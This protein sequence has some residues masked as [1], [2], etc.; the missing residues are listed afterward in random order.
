MLPKLPYLDPPASVVSSRILDVVEGR[1]FVSRVA[2]VEKDG[3]PI[4]RKQTT[5]ELAER[6]HALLSLLD[7]DHFPKPISSWRD[8]VASVC[9]MERVDGYPLSDLERFVAETSPEGARAFLL[10][11]VEILAELAARGI[12]H[13]D[14]R[15]DNI[16]VRDGRPVLIDFGW[17]VSPQHPYI[18][19]GGLG[20]AGRAPEGFCDAYAMG[21]AL[22]PAF[23]HHPELLHVLAAM[24]RPSAAGRV[25]DPAAL[26]ELVDAGSPAPA[27]VAAAVCRIA[28]QAIASGALEPAQAALE[29]ALELAPDD[30]ALLAAAGTVRLALGDA[31]AAEALLER[32]L[33]IDPENLTARTGLAHAAVDQ[34]RV[35][36]A[37]ERYAA[38]PGEA[39]AATIVIPV[40]N[41]VDLTRQCLATLA[42]ST[43]SH[44]YEVVVVDNGSTDETAA[45]LRRAR[46]A[47][48]LRAVFNGENLGFGK[49]CN[50]GASLARGSSIVLLNNDTIPGEGWLEALL[51]VAVD[52]TVGIVGSRLLYPDGRLQHAGIALNAQGLPYHIHRHEPAQF[53]PALVQRDFPA[54]TG[55]SM[56]L[57][58]EVYEQLGGFDEMFQM[59]VEDVDLC[60]RA[61]EAGLRV[62]YCPKSLLVHLESASV[63]DLARR[64]EQVRTGWGLLRSRWDGKFATPPWGGQEPERP[65]VTLDGVRSFA[66]LAF[67]DE[68]V[69]HPEILRTYTDTFGDRDDAS[70]VIY[71]PGRQPA[72]IAGALGQ[73]MRQAGS[74]RRAAPT[75]SSSPPTAAARVRP[76]SPVRSTRPTRGATATVPSRASTTSTT[77]ASP[78]CGCSR[79]G[80]GGAWRRELRSSAARL[81]GLA[82]RPVR[83]RGRGSRIPDRAR[84]DGPP[85]RG[86]RH[87]LHERPGAAPVGSPAG[88]RRRD[89][90]HAGGRVRPRPPPHPGPEPAAA[91]RGPRRRPDDVRDYS[92]PRAWLPRLYECDEVWVPCEFNLE[93]F[94]RGGFP[95]DRLRVLPET[96]DFDLFDPERTEP[97]AAQGARGFTFLTNFDFTDR[98]GWDVLLDAW[99]DA[100]DADDDVCLVLKCLGLHVPES[101]IRGRIDAY[102]GGRPA[103]PILLD[104]PTCSAADTRLYAAP[105]VRARE[106]RRGLGPPVITMAMGLRRSAAAGAVPRCSCTTELVACRRRRRRRARHGARARGLLLQRPAAGSIPTRARS[107]P[108]SRGVPAPRRGGREG[109]RARTD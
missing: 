54:V 8:G 7:S 57:R 18:T 73:A 21:V 19:P 82:V 90:A 10:E 5:F 64:D 60:L 25:T 43:P 68:L 93:T 103:A 22:T 87:P 71:A 27:E 94:Q 59:Y 33:E 91:C 12:T 50:L 74:R 72:E 107:P 39:P 24:T 30:A 58:R 17:A 11:C 96:I 55:A 92:V 99:C 56:L 29:R 36:E 88:R 4:V 6:E 102:L 48:M 52:E 13:R 77:A 69:A 20:D 46:A 95:G 67:A 28:E 1:P 42:S 35:D 78:T 61:W 44:L 85:G 26:R 34:G 65:Q 15:S 14:I 62:V 84:P 66:A 76:R 98:K 41:R 2:F 86:A 106:P 104:T 47:G 75:C 80:A 81:D 37:R 40:M 32:A 100:F 89:R 79:S 16:L 83:L 9:E 109:R 105:C 70:L 97:L 108:R 23:A 49:A 53:G 101:E 3:R 45:F 63:T 51:E 38:L 31:A